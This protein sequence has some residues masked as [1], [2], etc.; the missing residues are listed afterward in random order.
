METGRKIRFVRIDRGL[1]VGE[2]ADKAGINITTLSKIENGVNNNT[3]VHTLTHIA[4]ALEV[5][6]DWLTDESQGYPPG[7]VEKKKERRKKQEV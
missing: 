2:L 6:L 4:E 3:T 1:R 7:R 5:S